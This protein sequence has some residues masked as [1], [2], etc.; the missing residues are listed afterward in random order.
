MALDLALTGLDGPAVHCCI[1]PG[2]V[3]LDLTLALLI[4]EYF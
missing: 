4:A 3:Y 2:G 1:Y